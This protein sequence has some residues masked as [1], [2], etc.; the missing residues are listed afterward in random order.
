MFISLYRVVGDNQYLSD[1]AVHLF[2]QSS[3]PIKEIERHLDGMNSDDILESL[4]SPGK[5]RQS[6]LSRS[7]A[8]IP[9]ETE[10]CHEQDSGCCY[11]TTSSINDFSKYLYFG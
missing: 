1:V 9:H 4:Q 3:L 5:G 2:L 10:G 8:E 7:M 11:S 6:G